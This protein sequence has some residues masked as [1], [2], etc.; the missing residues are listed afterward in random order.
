MMRCENCTSKGNEHVEKRERKGKSLQAF[1]II[2]WIN[3][4]NISLSVLFFGC[5]ISYFSEVAF[6]LVKDHCIIFQHF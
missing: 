6:Y 2:F 4:D 1:D 5:S 3:Q